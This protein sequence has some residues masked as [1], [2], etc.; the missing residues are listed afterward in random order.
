M[1][2]TPPF[3]SESPPAG[4]TPLEPMETDNNARLW[5]T[6][7]H[8]SALASFIG[9]PPIVGPLVIW[10]VKRNE[11]PFVDDQGKEAVNFQITMLIAIVISIPLMCIVVG[12]IT[13]SLV[14]L[15]DLVMTI[16]ASIK[17]NQGIRFRYPL[18]LRLIK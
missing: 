18:T 15:F 5:G 13:A 17:A 14:G 3:G 12:F 4:Q 6:L 16:I 8:L 9:I 7:A 1:T 10:L 11:M 2:E